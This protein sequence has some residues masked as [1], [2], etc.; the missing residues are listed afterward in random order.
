[1]IDAILSLM[2][3]IA[4]AFLTVAGILA[5]LIGIEAVGEWVKERKG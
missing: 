2:L 3:I 1:M 5:L 4:G